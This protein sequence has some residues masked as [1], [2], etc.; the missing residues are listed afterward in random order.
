MTIS[1]W[2]VI[3]V[4]VAA[5]QA[6]DSGEEPSIARTT[7][8]ADSA[9]IRVVK[10]AAPAP[11]DTVTAEPLWTYGAVPPEYLFQRV[12][13]GAFR[14]DGAAVIADTGSDE[15]VRI[16]E[17]GT[18]HAILARTGQGPSEVRSPRQ[19]VAGPGGDLWVEDFWGGKLMRVEGDAFT[20]ILTGSDNPAVGG[21]LM[22]IGVDS[23]G[24]LMLMTGGYMPG[25]EEE[26]LMGVLATFTPGS[27]APDT[28]G[29]FQ[30]VQRVGEPP[31]FPFRGFGAADVAGESFVAARTD[32]PELVWRASNGRVTQIASWPQPPRPATNADWT[33]FTEA[34]RIDSERMNPGRTAAY[35]DSMTARVLE[36]YNLNTSDPV[37]LFDAIVGARDGSVWIASF[38]AG[39]SAATA[40]E[41]RVISREGE[42][43]GVVQFPAETRILDISPG[44]ILG[45]QKGV[46]D[47]ETVV[48]FE[49]PF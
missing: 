8:V 43:V 45:V 29:G 20:T 21:Q 44:R 34:A 49:N 2:A 7:E 30:F 36:G 42:W 11:T 31:I 14:E 24:R 37:R 16:S 12:I 15:V 9:G 28:V 22:P 33:E 6:C 48:V 13:G 1:R 47:V 18:G 46:L 5:F 38:T 40:E 41:W 35:H 32:V 27:E 19:V 17:D 3:A 25:F 26:W 23:S 39:S 4:A 10:I